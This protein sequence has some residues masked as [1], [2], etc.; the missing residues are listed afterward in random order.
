MKTVKALTRY[1]FVFV[2]LYPSFTVPPAMYIVKTLATHRKSYYL[3]QLLAIAHLIKI[4]YAGAGYSIRL[5]KVNTCTS[6]IRKGAVYKVL[7]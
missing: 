5:G 6:T 7:L 3:R 1:C 4:K 2:N